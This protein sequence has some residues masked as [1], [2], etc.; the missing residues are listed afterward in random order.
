MQCKLNN[1]EIYIQPERLEIKAEAII[2]LIRVT[3]DA[4]QLLQRNTKIGKPV[5]SKTFKSIHY[6]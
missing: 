2:K 1:P 4:E 6:L 3:F 5:G